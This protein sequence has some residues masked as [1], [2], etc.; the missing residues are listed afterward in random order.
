MIRINLL[1]PEIVE[2]RKSE[3]RFLYMIASGVL[4][5]AMVGAVA[6]YLQVRVGHREAELLLRE[7]RAVEFKAEAERY[8]IF[9]Q[10]KQDL[11]ARQ[12]IVDQALAGR[13]N[14]ARLCSELSLVLPDDVW[15]INL[16]LDEKEGLTLA[17]WSLDTTD[18]PDTGHKSIAKMLVRLADLEQLYNVWLLGSEKSVYI[19]NP[20]I[21]FQVRA[22]VNASGPTVGTSDVT[23]PPS[24]QGPT[25]DTTG[26][27]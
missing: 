23:A 22:S 18:T 16:S 19:E 25:S 26:G 15:A 3:R 13:V 1:P 5:F 8:R 2:K 20:A 27:G 17:G 7:Q 14:W 4:V 9:E 11:Q 24:D 6:L 21:S 10:K 12:A